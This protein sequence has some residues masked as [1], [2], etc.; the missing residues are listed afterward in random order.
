MEGALHSGT[1]GPAF[2]TH[3]NTCRSEFV[4]GQGPAQASETRVNDLGYIYVY[5]EQME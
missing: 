3:R 1:L 2:R 4:R 5:S